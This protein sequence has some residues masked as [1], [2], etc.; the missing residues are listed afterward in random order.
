MAVGSLTE[1]MWTAVVQIELK[2][3]VV[4]RLCWLLQFFMLQFFRG[5]G[6]LF[7]PC[8]NLSFIPGT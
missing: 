4:V 6:G 7:R 3:R 8:R 2:E 5:G 1:N